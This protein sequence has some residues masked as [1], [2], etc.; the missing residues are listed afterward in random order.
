MAIFLQHLVLAGVAVSAALMG[1][2][3]WSLVFG[4]LAGSVAFVV[5]L[6]SYER[7]RFVPKL[8]RSLARELMGFGKHLLATG[9][10][11][12]LIFNIDQVAIGK[13]LGLAIL[14]FYVAAIRIG[15]TMG[16]Q[17]AG[18][19]N[20]VLFP[21]M[22]R[23][24]EDM[25]RLRRGYAQSLKMISVI[26]AP[27]CMGVSAVSPVLVRVALGPD[28]D[29]VVVPLSIIAFQGMFNSLITPAANVL[30][31]IGKPYF[32]SGQT[33]V[34]AVIIVVGIYPVTNSYGIDGVCYFTT[35]VSLGVLVYFFFVFRMI[36][37]AS[38]IDVVRPVLPALFGATVMFI[39]VAYLATL[40]SPTLTSLLL[41]I[42][43]AT[44]IY[45]GLLY[46]ITRG[47]EIRELLDMIKTLM[48]KQAE[49]PPG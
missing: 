21:T 49:P 48:T 6:Q 19:V 31:S 23:I 44:A 45:F 37:R 43:L 5:T 47:K 26:T 16:D 20:K 10:L 2:G 32:M 3:Y 24:K 13:V 14:G 25:E 30:I 38:T 29:A 35:F 17:V 41:L 42:M 36:F 7:A 18:T 33:A 34:Q 40:V 12:Y 28:W 8:D 9:L 1:Y 46:V 11:A 22:A 4:S 27:L 15:R 39:A